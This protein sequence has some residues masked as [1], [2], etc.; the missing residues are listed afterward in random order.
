M[1]STSPRGIKKGQW[2]IQKWRNLDSDDKRILD[3]I[4]IGIE[5]EY[6]ILH[7]TYPEF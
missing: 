2:D 1:Q 3:G 7:F 6:Y 5:E 4:L